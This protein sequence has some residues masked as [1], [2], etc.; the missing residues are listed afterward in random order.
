MRKDLPELTIRYDQR[1]RRFV[2]STSYR[3]SIRPKEKTRPF[4]IAWPIDELKTHADSGEQAIGSAVL[5][6]FDRVTESGVGLKDYRTQAELDE[7]KILAD[8][9]RSAKT[10]DSSAQ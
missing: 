1:N 9:E 3:G 7:E 8:L 6:F 5:A 10:D 2:L 4:S